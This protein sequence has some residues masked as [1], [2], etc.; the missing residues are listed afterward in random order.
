MIRTIVFDMGNVLLR[1][2]PMLFIAR[3]GVAEPAD[4]ALLNR[5]LFRSLEWVQMDR[6]SLTEAKALER[7]KQR[8][9]ERLHGALETLILH[10]DEPIIPI[11]GMEQLVRDCKAAGY[12]LLLF[13]NASA[14]LHS[15][16][17][18]IPGHECFDGRFVS[19][20]HM[21]VKPQQ[22]C[23]RKFCQTFGVDGAECVFIDDLP[24]NIE[25]AV[26]AG[27]QGLVF[28]DAA[29]LRADLRRLGVLLPE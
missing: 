13:S 23:Y 29:A 12:K 28:H 21:L 7:V 18:R 22:S 9:P 19:A 26:T 10:W 27:W 2:D 11:P 17:D 20:D 24:L 25:G 4:A 15:Y 16:W 1:F 8:V 3:A 6:G 5:E 14:R